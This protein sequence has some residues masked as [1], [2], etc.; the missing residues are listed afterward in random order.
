MSLKYSY[1]KLEAKCVHCEDVQHVL[2]FP[3]L[4]AA[5]C[6]NVHCE[7]VQHVLYCLVLVAIL[8]LNVLEISQRHI[9][10]VGSMRTSI[11][12]Q[13]QQWEVLEH[14]LYSLDLA[15]GDFQLLNS[16]SICNLLIDLP[17]YYEAAEHIYHGTLFVPCLSQQGVS[18]F[19]RSCAVSCSVLFCMT[20]DKMLTRLRKTH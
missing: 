10:L 6:L 20:L 4:V 17:S 15:P 9:C 18:L 14:P 12:M 2:Q 3:L 8:C 11:V 19:Q 7:D 13:E 16:I 5:L 1:A